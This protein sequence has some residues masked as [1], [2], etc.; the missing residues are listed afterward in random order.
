MTP[1]RPPADWLLPPGVSRGLWDYLHSP[2]VARGYDDALAGSTLF[3]ADERF[4]GRHCPAPGRLIDLGC[5]TGRLLL[6]LARR[7]YRVLGV[8]LS[9]EMLA[10]A[11]EKSA[12]AGLP[13]DL[14]RAN[15]AELDA[16]AGDS[17]DYAACLFSTLGMVAGAEARRRVL[18]HAFR[19]LRPGG[20]FVLHVH[21]RWFNALD[22]SGRRWLL[23][24]LLASAVGRAAAGD[25][26]MPV[27]QGVAGLTLHLF[28]R[29]EAARLLRGAGFRVVEVE[30][31]GLAEGGQLR[32]PRW[33]G[34]VRAYGYLLAAEKPT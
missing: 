10:V 27:H 16:V 28:T 6:A 3:V 13:V 11:R 31:V 19:V 29:G 1:A 22:P 21:N 7:G 32:S 26:E 18:M 12:V 24:N 34:R 20:R 9:P 5:G 15:L 23:G 14:L 8:D 17:F 25:R 2:S 30:A 33:F 4:V